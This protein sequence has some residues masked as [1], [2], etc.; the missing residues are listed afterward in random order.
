[1]AEKLTIISDMWGSKQGLWITS[2]LG[3]LQQYYSIEYYDSKQLA[4]IDLMVNT[5]SNIEKAFLDG[6]IQ[7]AADHL[8]SRSKES[9]HY[10]AFGVGGSIAWQA[11]LKGLP[12]KSLYLVSSSFLHRE[13]DRPSVPITVLCGGRDENILCEK[14]GEEMG[15]RMET[16]KK[17]GHSLYSDEIVIQ[18]ICL[19]LLRKVTKITMP[20]RKVV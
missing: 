8:V 17:F 6:G 7:R 5:R 14:W 2:Y 4:N 10:L 19:D 9:A 20:K 15:V 11:A 12:A 16:I 3:Y 18:K 13:K 1:M